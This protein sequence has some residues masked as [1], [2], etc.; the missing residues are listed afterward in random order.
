MDGGK[1]GKGKGFDK[2][3]KGKGPMQQQQMMQQQQQQQMMEAPGG[4]HSPEAAAKIEADAESAM[5]QATRAVEE[6]VAVPA[7]NGGIAS[8]SEQV[9]EQAVKSLEQLMM[10]ARAKVKEAQEMIMKKLQ[11]CSRVQTPAFAKLKASLPKKLSALA[12]A[13]PK[14]SKAKAEVQK[15]ADDLVM[16]KTMGELKAKFATLEAAGT[17]VEQLAQ[18][19]LDS[20]K[21]ENVDADKVVTSTSE[22]YA[23]KE[24]F[25]KQ[26]ADLKTQITAA[27]RQTMGQ[28]SADAGGLKKGAHELLIGIAQLETKVNQALAPV[29]T[30]IETA[31]TDLGV[32]AMAKKVEDAKTTIAEIIG[33][34]DL[35]VSVDDL[36]VDAARERIAKAEKA[37]ET[38]T[39][40]KSFH[41]AL[42]P[43]GGKGIPKAQ[44]AIRMTKLAPQTQAIQQLESK[45]F[46]TRSVANLAIQKVEAA[47]MLEEVQKEVTPAEELSQKV[48]DAAAPV[49]SAKP[50]EP[51]DMSMEDLGKLHDEVAKIGDEAKNALAA[52][53][54]KVVV[55]M[56]DMATGAGESKRALGELNVKLATMEARVRQTVSGIKSALDMK[57]VEGETADITTKIVALEKTTEEVNSAAPEKLKAEP[58]EDT[59]KEIEESVKKTQEEIQ[60]EIKALGEMIKE[61]TSTEAD[62]KTKLQALG[63][64]KGRL[65]AC[66][67]KLAKLVL[68]S[69]VALNMQQF[70]G[71]VA[72]LEEDVARASGEVNQALE[73]KK[74][75]T[76]AFK[77]MEKPKQLEIA[78]SV[79]D[80]LRLAKEGMSDKATKIQEALRKVNTAGPQ[81]KSEYLERLRKLN[82]EF[83]KTERTC[84]T[85]ADESM[86]LLSTIKSSEQADTLQKKAEEQKKAVFEFVEEIKPMVEGQLSEEE[87]KE[88]Q[89]KAKAKLEEFEGPVKALVEEIAAVLAEIPK[90]AAKVREG[91][92]K[93]EAIVKGLQT[94]LK[95][96]LELVDSAATRAKTKD[97][98]RVASGIAAGIEGKINEVVP[99]LKELNEKAADEEVSTDTVA[100]LCTAFSAI[101]AEVKEEVEKEKLALMEKGKSETAKEVPEYGREIVRSTTKLQQLGVK[102]GSM[103][104]N[105]KSLVD[106]RK[107]NDKVRDVKTKLKV[108]LEAAAKII[109]EAAPLEKMEGMTEAEAK[110]LSG[111]VMKKATET[112]TLLESTG[113]KLAEAASSSPGAVRETQQECQTTISKLRVARSI[114]ESAPAKAEMETVKEAVKALSNCM[115]KAPGTDGLS[116]DVLGQLLAGVWKGDKLADD[117]VKRIF[118]FLNPESA[119]VISMDTWNRL[120]QNLYV[121]LAGVALTDGPTIGKGCKILRQLVPDE[122][123]SALGEP[124]KDEKTQC[125]RI[126]VKTTS[127]SLDGYVTEH[128]NQGTVYLGSCSVYLLEDFNQRFIKKTEADKRARLLAQGAK[129]QV[130]KAMAVFEGFEQRMLPHLE[131]AAAKVQNKARLISMQATRETGDVLR[132]INAARSVAE[133]RKDALGDSLQTLLASLTDAEER[134]KELVQRFE[135]LPA[136]AAE[137]EKALAA[138]LPDAVNKLTQLVAG[139]EGGISVYVAALDKDGDGSLTAEEIGGLLDSAE[140]SGDMREAVQDR[141]GES[142]LVSAVV[143]LVDRRYKCVAKVAM[144]GNFSMAEKLVMVRELA[145]GEEVFVLDGPTMDPK[146]QLERVKVKASD[147]SEG[148]VSVKGNQG[149]TYLE[150]A[151]AAA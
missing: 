40:I 21:E 43:P 71:I 6:A 59:L 47:A 34:T 147:G 75:L 119:G 24:E 104:T 85:E 52:V 120:T 37:Q 66:N 103:L 48:Q 39:A 143:A 49:M 28:K 109:E 32:K 118:D 148:W 81:Y 100:E 98:C 62:N 123:V 79:Y 36:A 65:E 89:A 86:V 30:E 74:N 14:L 122:T 129:D 87:T 76:T 151:A 7:A 92:M 16:Q 107:T 35:E 144:L 124:Q 73:D 121:C 91:F 70:E 56:R 3:G 90:T 117:Q 102:L 60:A 2:G 146:A 57:K 8:A 113:V 149:T 50:G 67:G 41:Q 25:M 142:C 97:L 114:A 61:V 88:A 136:A 45:V 105:A 112:L 22:V 95:R 80:S 78:T 94:I 139:S 84:G 108:V 82:M 96:Q 15:A 23:K 115:M 135:K 145:V 13:E 11:E 130:F 42:L 72:G 1:K 58:T 77:E 19:I 46:K 31:K 18:T 4:P 133:T 44:F 141:L 55:K 138:A 134:L 137:R 53:K 17:M 125:M 29:L 110:R 64:L 20:L 54:N 83:Q 26:V 150:P 111:A 116:T 128:G 140:L 126:R 10:I 63:A 12:Q 132:Q 101:V 33:E 51:I 5:L 131:G 27:V 38:I 99:K 93:I 9:V 69:K 127:D 106:R 68:T